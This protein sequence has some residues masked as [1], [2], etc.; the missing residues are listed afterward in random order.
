MKLLT[1]DN[2]AIMYSS[3]RVMHPFNDYPLPAASKVEFRVIK[4]HNIMGCFDEIDMAIEIS[5]WGCGHY[6]T[7]LSTLLHEMT[8]QALYL[9][10]D[11]K[12]SEHKGSFLQLKRKYCEFYNLDPK[13]I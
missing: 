5:E 7:I 6:T 8:H 11:P 9:V 2:L 1:P 13:A 3:A 10:H 12:W 4:S